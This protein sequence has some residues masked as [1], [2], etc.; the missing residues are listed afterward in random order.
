MWLIVNEKEL[1]AYFEGL[2][3]LVRGSDRPNPPQDSDC[4]AEP[5]IRKVLLRY[6]NQPVVIGTDAGNVSGILQEVGADYAQIAE[7]AGS[8]VVIPF[9][10]IN[11]VHTT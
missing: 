2:K 7:S 6:I 9:T 11:F 1:K 5:E 8:R 3:K 4:P 10:Q